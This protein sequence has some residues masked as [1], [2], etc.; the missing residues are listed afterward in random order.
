[1]NFLL[2]FLAPESGWRLKQT[3]FCLFVC[4]TQSA[5]TLVAASF[6]SDIQALSSW[7]SLPMPTCSTLGNEP[8]ARCTHLVL[9]KALA[10]FENNGLIILLV[11]LCSLPKILQEGG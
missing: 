8:Q 3:L 4:S 9:H 2:S 1:M 6:L 10:S 7:H 11:S 5:T